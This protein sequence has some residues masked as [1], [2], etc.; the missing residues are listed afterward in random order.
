MKLSR[1]TNTIILWII[2]LGLLLGM[3]ITFTPTLG[4]LG[5]GNRA[6]EGRPAL[7]VNG[8]AIR[9]LEVARARQNP[10]FSAVR[11]GP[12][13]EDLELLMVDQ[14]VRQE[15]FDQAAAKTRVSGRDVRREVENFR[16]AQGVAGRGNDR[17]YLQLIGQSGFD[18]QSFRAYLE[19][20]LRREK[21]EASLTEDAEVSDAEVET[22]YLANADRYRSEDRVRARM[23]TVDDAELANELRERARAGEDFAELA[24]EHSLERADRAGAVGAPQGSTEPQP[25]GR[26]ALPQTVSTEVFG[27][28]GPGLSDVIAAGNRYYLVQV[29]EYVPERARPLEE[30]REEVR[31]DALA[32]KRAGIVQRHLEELLAQA[33]VEVP[34][35]SEVEYDDYPVARVGE[36]QIMA[37]DLALATYT[38]RQIRDNLRPELE[39]LIV[40]FFKPTV[41]ETMIERKLAYLGADELDGEFVGSEEQIAAQALAY[42]S[43]DAELDEAA[44]EEYYEANARRF[45]V[46]AEADATRVEFESQQEAESF[47]SALLDGSALE[48]AAEEFGGEVTD[49]GSVVAGQ[50]EEPVDRA[51]FGTDAFDSL[52]DSELEVSDVLVMTAPSRTEKQDGAEEAGEE[53]AESAEADAAEETP[54]SEEVFVVLVA[55]RTPEQVRPLQEVR[56]QV[57]QA[58][59]QAER[60]E[61]ENRWLESLSEDIE[62]QNLLAQASADSTEESTAPDAGAQE[63]AETDGADAATEGAETQ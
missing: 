58:V 25:V 39:S 22:Y 45:T 6:D 51:L 18:D 47:R 34:E 43:R 9:E 10:L 50:L 54:E 21:Y 24:R 46:P 49:L 48:A 56:D 3:V 40:D 2:S 60:A 52:P 38:N 59:L 33:R 63:S 19:Q 62:V 35:D 55:Q 5:G 14:L 4:G 23:I 31:S 29:E 36:E 37:S 61:I 8:E 41:L 11:E 13:G 17:A 42:V 30:V 44:V 7:L 57:E 32:A 53:P 12:V 15:V 26:A 20:Q 1:R 16:E 27:L 28:R